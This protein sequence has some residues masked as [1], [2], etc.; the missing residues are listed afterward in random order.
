VKPEVSRVLEVT[1]Q[2]LLTEIAPHVAPP[3]RQA[4]V[5]GAALLLGSIRE[6]LDRIAERRVEENR[7][8]CALFADAQAVVEDAALRARLSEAA[9]A[10]EPG[11][12]ISALEARNAALRELLIALHAH[13]ETLA[14]PAARRVEAA[15]WREL[16]ASTVRRRLSLNAF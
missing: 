3:Y 4:S 15:I 1:A 6:E 8:L 7:A 11:F 14:A 10:V 9:N 5:L 12:R 13:V 2:A 16:A